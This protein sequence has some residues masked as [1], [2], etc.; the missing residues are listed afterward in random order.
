MSVISVKGLSKDY[1]GSPALSKLDL[2]V[3]EG[4][5]YGFL[6]PNGSGKTTTIKI[7]MGLISAT[8]GSASILNRPVSLNME[9]SLKRRIGYLPEE[10]GF[11]ESLTGWEVMEFAYRAA[12]LPKSEMKREVTGLMVKFKLAGAARRRWAGYSRGMKQRLGLAC[13]LLHRPEL[14]ILDEPVSALDPE[15]RRELLEL[16]VSLRGRATVFFSSHVLADVERVCD[17]VAI[18]N[19]GRL[20]TESPL[21]ELLGR[22]DFPQY[23][24]SLR[25]APSAKLVAGVENMTWAKKVKLNGKDLTV[26]TLPGLVEQLEDELLPALFRDGA[27]VTS[28]YPQ[29]PNLEE[30]FLELLRAENHRAGRKENKDA[31]VT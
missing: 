11:P 9:R 6:G 7:L 1:S 24:V 27:T 8:A 31:V 26:E 19:E 14:L 28:F 20:V 23:H 10:F 17:H 12:D 4:A 2:D 15:G 21:P 25:E 30:V 22:Y 16:I 5:V 13:T 18:L 3:P 29:R